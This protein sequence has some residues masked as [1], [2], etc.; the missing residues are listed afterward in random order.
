MQ[1]VSSALHPQGHE[2]AAHSQDVS[3][4]QI[5]RLKCMIL[6][7]WCEKDIEGQFGH[8]WSDYFPGFQ[9]KKITAK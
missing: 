3:L 4:R 6:D 2:D 8:G 7:D 9:D 1:P 5:M